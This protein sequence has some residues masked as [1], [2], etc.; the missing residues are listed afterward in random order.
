MKTTSIRRLLLLIVPLALAAAAC[1]GTEEP[2]GSPTPSGGPAYLGAKPLTADLSG[3][4]ATTSSSDRTTVFLV[5][6]GCEIDGVPDGYLVVSEFG[7]FSL[8]EQMAW[9][10]MVEAFDAADASDAAAQ[11]RLGWAQWQLRRDFAGVEQIGWTADGTAWGFLLPTIGGEEDGVDV[12]TPFDARFE[13]TFDED[14]NA[15]GAR[16]VEMCTLPGEWPGST[17]TIEAP[18]CPATS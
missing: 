13:I 7:A 2:A 4:P 11:L 16:F 8:S 3:C 12:V 10:A 17:V 1:G 18:T 6:D 9:T 14:G 5:G 15:D